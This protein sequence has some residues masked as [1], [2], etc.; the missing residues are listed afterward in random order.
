MNALDKT[1][2]SEMGRCLT[3]EEWRALKAWRTQNPDCVLRVGYRRADGLIFGGWIRECRNGEWWYTAEQHARHVLKIQECQRKK[4]ERD[5]KEVRNQ[6]CAEWR[7][8]HH[9]ANPDKYARHLAARR[10][11]MRRPDV[12][13][14]S[15]ARRLEKHRTDPVFHAKTLAALN[16]WKT[17]NAGAV[18]AS[19]KA[20][21][22]LQKSRFHPTASKRAIGMI[23]RAS[24]TLSRCT[25][26][27]H[28]VD[29]IIPL[30]SGGWHHELNLQ[31][32]P[33]RVNL[34]KKKNPLW[35]SDV[36][37][38]WRSV[39]ESLWPA[40]LAPRYRAILEATQ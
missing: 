30:R 25:G 17:K 1:P 22:A 8:R 31:V 11:Y 6:R 37:L 14:R 2:W 5:G 39:P 35:T 27:R 20:R 32:L 7:T 21:K 23:Y 16:L 19:I 15:T 29:H 12:R 40:E 38:D 13:E 28:H 3:S 26:I 10:E 4:L 36:Y 9:A 34:S 18:L 24:E 33:W